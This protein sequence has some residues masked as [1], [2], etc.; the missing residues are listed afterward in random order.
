MILK[1]ENVPYRHNDKMSINMERV[2]C[3]NTLDPNVSNITVRGSKYRCESPKEFYKYKIV[4]EVY[5][6]IVE[7]WCVS[8]KPL[9]LKKPDGI[10]LTPILIKHYNRKFN[11][12][13]VYKFNNNI[14]ELK[15]TRA[16]TSGEFNS[17]GMHDNTATALSEFIYEFLNDAIMYNEL[18]TVRKIEEFL[19]NNSII[20]NDVIDVEETETEMC[21]LIKYTYQ[22][23]YSYSVAKN[24]FYNYILPFFKNDNKMRMVL[25]MNTIDYNYIN[26]NID[27]RTK[28][29]LN[30]KKA[31]LIKPYTNNDIDQ[32]Y[33]IYNILMC[34]TVSPF[35]EL[36][37]EIDLENDK[38]KYD[39]ATSYISIVNMY[40]KYKEIS[41]TV[42]MSNIIKFIELIDNNIKIKRVCVEKLPTEELYI[43]VD[44]NKGVLKYYFDLFLNLLV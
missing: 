36:K 43:E 25:G 16:I 11:S 3:D 1:I 28:L 8:P 26:S 29:E 7:R 20:S 31:K 4:E 27:K 37:M 14:E 34:V 2:R 15:T 18:K 40:K 23:T 41:T 24:I 5:N 44:T 21:D 10:K 19:N 6:D 13:N 38:R 42:L 12:I 9:N 35:K 32:L 22:Y 30:N 17:L 33:Y 39:V